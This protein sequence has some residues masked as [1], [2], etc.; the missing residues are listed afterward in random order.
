MPY[1][2][3]NNNPILP[4]NLANQKGVYVIYALN[5][6]ET[7]QAINRVLK[8]DILGRLYIGQT[9]KQTFKDRLDMFR[10]VMNPNYAATAHSGGLNLKEIPALRN[11]FP[12]NCIYVQVFPHQNPKAEEERMIEAYRQEFGEVPPLNG[13]K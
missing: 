12:S 4:A 13:S 1:Y 11:R 7:P 9:T 5:P 2:S 3:I 6:N 8:T 10:R